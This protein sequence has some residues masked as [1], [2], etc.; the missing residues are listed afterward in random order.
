MAE[1]KIQTGAANQTM[2]RPQIMLQLLLFVK[3]LAGFMLLAVLPVWPDF[4]A[5]LRFR[6][7][8][9]QR[10]CSRSKLFLF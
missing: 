6:C 4:Y 2:S 3:P 1:K 9:W 7:W 5:P 8:V 10:C